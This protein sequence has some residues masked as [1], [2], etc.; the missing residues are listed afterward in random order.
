MKSKEIQL[1][2]EKL[3]TIRKLSVK[4]V[5]MTE[6]LVAGT[7][8][9]KVDELKR[10]DRPRRLQVI[11]VR[12]IMLNQ[13]QLENDNPCSLNYI[14]ERVWKNISGGYPSARALYQYCNQHRA[15]LGIY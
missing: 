3:E 14:C 15:Q 8:E 13:N 5:R 2:L 12:D 10:L 9:K 11:E 6:T 1:V 7:L 4:T